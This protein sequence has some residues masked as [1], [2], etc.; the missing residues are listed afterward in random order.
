MPKSIIDVPPRENTTEPLTAPPTV[1][2]VPS[3]PETFRLPRQ[4]ERD[5]YW[6]LSRAWYYEAEKSGA[7]KLIRLRKRGNIR[8]V[9]LVPFQAVAQMVRN[10]AQHSEL[11]AK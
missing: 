3:H 10:A 2:G 11:P 1:A 5:P 6:G 9:T 8:G 4:N 7:L